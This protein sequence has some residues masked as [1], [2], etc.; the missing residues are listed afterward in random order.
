MKP[1][2]SALTRD[3]HRNGLGCA[4][5]SGNTSR[6]PFSFPTA[7]QFLE[8]QLALLYKFIITLVLIAE[9]FDRKHV[10]DMFQSVDYLGRRK[11]L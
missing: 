2:K 9:G 6:S 4:I 11:E 3:K 1:W 8:Q 7:F 10:L 5:A